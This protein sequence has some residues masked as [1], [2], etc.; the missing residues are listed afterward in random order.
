MLVL[1]WLNRCRAN[2]ITQYRNP[3]DYNEWSWPREQWYSK[4]AYND[5]T[6]TQSFAPWHAAAL[7]VQP[8]N[9]HQSRSYLVSASF[10]VDPQLWGCSWSQ[11]KFWY[12]WSF[13]SSR[14]VCHTLAILLPLAHVSPVCVVWCF[15][16]S[17]FHG[18]RQKLINGFSQ[19]DS[20][21]KTS[22]FFWWI[23]WWYLGDC[24]SRNVW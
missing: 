20:N 16:G 18:F 15:D 2:Q 21:Q 3:F 24:I 6:S 22:K 1:G 10:T 9:Q 5:L 14:E 17:P 4:H 13:R 11:N 12:L 8:Q 7:L 23:Y 19:N